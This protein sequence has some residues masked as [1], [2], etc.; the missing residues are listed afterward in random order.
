[1]S[2]DGISTLT[3]TAPSD[4]AAMTDLL[5]DLS[6]TA[7]SIT[8]GLEDFSLDLSNATSSTG[9]AVDVDASADSVTTTINDASVGT[10]AEWSI[11]GPVTGD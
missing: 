2:F 11:T 3:Y 6:I 10:A 1:M 8:E 9:V 4:G 5:I 7:D